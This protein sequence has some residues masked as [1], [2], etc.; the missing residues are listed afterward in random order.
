M[1]VKSDLTDLDDLIDDLVETYENRCVLDPEELDQLVVSYE[2]IETS[3]Q[4]HNKVCKD[5]YNK[6]FTITSLTSPAR[7]AIILKNKEL[8]KEYY[9]KYYQNNKNKK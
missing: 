5:Y 1:S 8:R 7:N 4:K 9:K 6:H 2:K 3:R